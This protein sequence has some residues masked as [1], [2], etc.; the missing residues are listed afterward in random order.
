MATAPAAVTIAGMRTFPAPRSAEASTFVIHPGIA[1][2]KRTFAY[3]S[4]LA[5]VSPSAPR[6]TNSALP[7][8]Q[9]P[10]LKHAPKTTAMTTACIT[11]AWA[12]FMRSAPIARAMAEDTPPPIPP[13]DIFDIIV[14][15]MNTGKTRA[16]PAIALVPR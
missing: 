3:K 8:V 14:I 2:A 4:A 6:N 11:S 12:S 16:T 5:S 13:F 10:M 1:A 15:S 7:A 9:T